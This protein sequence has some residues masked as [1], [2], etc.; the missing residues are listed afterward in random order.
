MKHP[1]KRW[2]IDRRVPPPGV[3]QSIYNNLNPFHAP[4]AAPNSKTMNQPSAFCQSLILNFGILSILFILSPFPARIANEAFS[5]RMMSS[6]P[7]FHP[8]ADDNDCPSGRRHEL[9]SRP[10][11]RLPQALPEN[12]GDPRRH[13]KSAAPGSHA[14]SRGKP[15]RHIQFET[16][17]P[18]IIHLDPPPSFGQL[19][20]VIIIRPLV[21]NKKCHKDA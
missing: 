4:I 8:P 7:H 21:L 12:V 20:N 10:S 5:L 11:R 17:R 9:A 6:R 14:P 18:L 13:G 19:Q 2:A 1:S 3:R 15:Y 16:V